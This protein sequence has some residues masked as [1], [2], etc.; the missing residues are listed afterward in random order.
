MLHPLL[1]SLWIPPS[2]QAVLISQKQQYS[3][4]IISITIQAKASYDTFLINI[5]VLNES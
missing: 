1:T 5:T 2:N 4:G 3:P